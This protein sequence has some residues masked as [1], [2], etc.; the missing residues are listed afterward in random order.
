MPSATILGSIPSS[1]IT[2]ECVLRKAA[3]VAT[4]REETNETP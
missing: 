2:V 4:C 1:R 3:R